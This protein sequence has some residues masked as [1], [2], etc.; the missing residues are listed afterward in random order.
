MIGIFIPM[1]K[2]DKDINKKNIKQ[3]TKNFFIYIFLF[4]KMSYI[5]CH[6][7]LIY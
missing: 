5:C 6:V 7:L 3:I 4:R 2:T 1:K